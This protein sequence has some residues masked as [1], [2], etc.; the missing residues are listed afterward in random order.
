MSNHAHRS[1][2]K[3][4]QIHNLLKHEIFVAAGSKNSSFVEKL[5]DATSMQTEIAVHLIMFVGHSH[6]VVDN[7]L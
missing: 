3:L 2:D 5:S 4:R 6:N 1:I 7:G